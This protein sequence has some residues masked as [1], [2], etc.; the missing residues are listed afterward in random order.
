M[1]DFEYRD[2][3]F[4]NLLEEIGRHHTERGAQYATSENPFENFDSA[5]K[6]V[7]RFLNPEI[8]KELWGMVSAEMYVTKQIDS[9]VSIL[10]N[11]EKMKDVR[12]LDVLEEH[13]TD[14]AVY[15]MIMVLLLRRYRSGLVVV[16]KV[17]LDSLKEGFTISRSGELRKVAAE[18][19]PPPFAPPPP[20]IIREDKQPKRGKE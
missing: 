10:S 1:T 19:V 13:L 2:D 14:I 7:G 4:M 11:P 5:G 16:P 12:L 9:V 6:M 15:N 3:D 20:R 17:H 8:P 18:K